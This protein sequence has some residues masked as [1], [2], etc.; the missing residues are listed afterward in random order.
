MEMTITMEFKTHFERAADYRAQSRRQYR[1]HRQSAEQ[2]AE[3]YRIAAQERKAAAELTATPGRW[4]WSSPA[5][6]EESA[7]RYVQLADSYLRSSMSAYQASVWYREN[8]KF[9]E[10]RHHELVA[11]YDA[12]QAAKAA[13]AKEN[14]DHNYSITLA[15]PRK[16]MGAV[17][18]YDDYQECSKCGDRR[19][20]P[21]PAELARE[22]HDK[23]VAALPHADGQACAY[24]GTEVYVAE[25]ARVLAVS[26]ATDSEEADWCPADPGTHHSQPVSPMQDASN[27][28]PNQ[29]CQR[30]LPNRQSVCPGC[31]ED[32]GMDD[33]PVSAMQ[34]EFDRG[35]PNL[36]VRTYSDQLIETAHL[37]GEEDLT[38]LLKPAE[39]HDERWMVLGL[40]WRE[41]AA[42]TNEAHL[43]WR[44]GTAGRFQLAADIAEAR[45]R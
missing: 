37:I 13:E 42:L 1:W 2:A 43:G 5:S 14:C 11:A 6:R 38:R 10:A 45:R 21:T 24:C 7:R 20:M 32:T 3:F 12:S 35:D 33:K 17:T 34:A 36:V 18:G 29:Q 26:A 31:G 41:A 27:Y 8:A 30:Y 16:S 23:L 15:F 25:D 39:Y 9:H 19:P 4:S 44:Y 28:C 40:G 22:R